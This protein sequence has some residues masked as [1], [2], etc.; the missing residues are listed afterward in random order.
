MSKKYFLAVSNDII[1]RAF[2]QLPKHASTILIFGEDENDW[3]ISSLFYPG[4]VLGA[5]FDDIPIRIYKD[6]SYISI[7]SLE[8]AQGKRHENLRKVALGALKKDKST[9][10]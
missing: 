7:P 3:Y 2:P 10:V 1:R 5:S 9:N 6:D 4:G 8:K